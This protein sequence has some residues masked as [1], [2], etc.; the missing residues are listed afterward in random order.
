[1]V[2]RNDITINWELSP[3]VITVLSPSTTIIIQD[4]IDTCRFAEVAIE[5]LIWPSIISA[6][7]KD[8][9]GG[10]LFVG[11]TTTLQNAV[12]AFQDL[13]GPSYTQCTV[14]GG[15]LV[16]VDATNTSISPIQPTAFTQV[17]LS[18]SSSS[19]LITGGSALTSEQAIQL[20][21]AKQYSLL[22]FIK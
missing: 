16:A 17:V 1:M 19:T 6:A 2:V 3:R 22:N 12:L 11:I 4:L 15:N 7:G 14:S 21:Q 10:G 8:N 18:S 5:N 20:S 9:L 13:S